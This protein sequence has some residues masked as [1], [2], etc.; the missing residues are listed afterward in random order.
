M[1][2]RSPPSVKPHEIEVVRGPNIK[3]FP[4]NTVLNSCVGKALIKV[5]DNITTDHI[6]PSN[7]SLLPF[8][9]NVPHLAEYCLA[10]CDPEFP[11]RAKHNG[12]GMII[13]GDNYGQGSSREH[14]ALAPLQLGIRAVIVKSFA[15]IHKANL[16]NSG[17]LPL[18]F[19]NPSDYDTIDVMDDLVVMH[20]RDQVEQGGDITMLNR[21][22]ELSYTLKLEVSDLER[23]MLLYGGKINM[24]K[25]MS[26]N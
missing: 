5:G 8:R 3:P 15:R 20:A 11:A 22:K 4:L 9:S 25:E 23:Q 12:G 26:N 13:G 10:P 2:F 1:L 24:I 19:A 14:A 17:I 7:A 16:I 21:S 18:V 6:M